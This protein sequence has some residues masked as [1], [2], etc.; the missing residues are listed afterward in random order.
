MSRVKKTSITISIL[1]SLCL[2]IGVFQLV[3]AG[4]A[5]NVTGYAWSENIGWISMNCTDESGSWAWF[6]DVSSPDE[7]H[8]YGWSDTTGWLSLN[9][10]EGGPGNTDI[11]ASVSNYKVVVNEATGNVSGWAW[12]DVLGWIT[13]NRP[14]AGTPPAA[15]YNGSETYIAHYDSATKTFSGW[16]KVLSPS[17]WDGWIQL[18]DAG[19]TGLHVLPDGTL[20]G[21]M[22]GGSVMGWVTFQEG[23]AFDYGVHVDPSTGDF[24]GWAWSSNI[25]WIKADPGSGYP[26]GPEMHDAQLESDNTVTGWMRACVGTA[27]NV[28]GTDVSRPDGWDGWISMSGSSPDYGVTYNGTDE[29]EGWAWGDE[30]IGWISFNSTNCD[31]DGNGLSDSGIAGCPVGGSNHWDKINDPYT[32]HDGF[33]RYVYSDAADWVED[34]YSFEDPPVGLPET[35]TTVTYHTVYRSSGCVQ[36]DISVHGFSATIVSLGCS[37][38]PSWNTRTVSI[39]DPEN[40]NWTWNDVRDIQA[41]LSMKEFSGTPAQV[42]QIYLRVTYD[43]GTQLYLYPDGD[44]TP[45]P[46]ISAYPAGGG[47]PVAIP[48]YAV[49]HVNNANVQPNANINLPLPNTTHPGDVTLSAVFDDTGGETFYAYKWY[50][51]SPNTSC[52]AIPT[53]PTLTG[54]AADDWAPVNTSQAI[55]PNGNYEVCLMVAD[56]HLGDPNQWSICKCVNITIG[57]EC[58]DDIDNETIPDG[59]FDDGVIGEGT[60]EDL[61]LADPACYDEDGNYHSDYNDESADPECSDGDDN[62][63]DGLF[64]DGGGDPD[65]ADPGC[66]SNF[67]VNTGVYNKF[68]RSEDSC[69][70]I[71]PASGELTCDQGETFGNCPSDCRDEFQFIEF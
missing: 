12:S 41:E 26:A 9:C 66:Y 49:K 52:E 62:D 7:L 39:S 11:C 22:F 68:G 43:G 36:Q 6:D 25:G 57:T 29:F 2:G 70:V 33:D 31:P 69:G 67:D 37:S 50:W 40:G 24:S 59:F 51:G 54:R 21:W 18:N 47:G 46:D 4:A 30:V 19:W 10:A 45:S 20:D 32:G 15:P 35:I 65:L 34:I 8:G 55:T 28:C 61:L 64:D 60:G 3:H 14:V 27:D 63:G 38:G 13:F 5:H 56:S 1:F 58:N 48:R 71:N 53:S 17:G 42:T 44:L 16:A 23:C